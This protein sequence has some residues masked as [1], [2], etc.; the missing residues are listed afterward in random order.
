MQALCDAK[1][2]FLFVSA[3]TPGRTNDF[4]AYKMSNL[5]SLIEQLP[6]GYWCG[7]D[8]V[9]VNTEHLL[10]PFPGQLI[11]PERDAFNFFLSQLRERIEN[12]FARY[13]N[14]WGIFWKPLIGKLGNHAKTIIVT[15][16]LHNFA[17]DEQ[18]EMP[19]ND[20]ERHNSVQHMFQTTTD[21]F[22]EP[23]LQNQ[24]E[25]LTRYQFTRAVNG[26]MLC[27]ELMAEI[28]F[29]GYRRSDENLARNNTRNVNIVPV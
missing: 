16:K 12:T 29:L 19:S 21:Q 11:S 17:I 3:M 20:D 7:R 2:H 10:S 1:L 9:Y 6:K 27:N 18:I 22:G 24:D 23:I 13:V 5:S 4:T 25:W 14:R 8:N 28:A 15:A 26:P